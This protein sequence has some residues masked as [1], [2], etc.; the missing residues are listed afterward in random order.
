MCLHVA[1]FVIP[2]NLIYN[3]TMFQKVEFRPFDLTSRGGGEGVC[4]Q[5]IRY[6]V[7]AFV[8]KFSLISNMTIF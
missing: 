7:S 3:M 5:N 1:A 4:R 2:F 8:N 6:H